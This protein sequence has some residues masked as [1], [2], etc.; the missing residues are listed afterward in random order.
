VSGH[1][2]RQVGRTTFYA[3]AAGAVVVD[4]ASKYAARAHLPVEGHV[5]IIPGYFALKLT[6]NAGA[7]FGV[8]RSWPPLVSLI[9]L[10]AIIAI[11]FLRKERSKSGVLAVALGLLLGGALGNLIDRVLFGY[12]TD[13]FDAGIAI[14][15]RVYTWPTFN[16]ADVAITSGVILLLYHVLMIERVERVE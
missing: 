16:V 6:E 2:R 3:S 15:G 12:V 1:S 14:A 8:L 13:F 11:I 9:G 10:A 5:D 4:Q 7:A